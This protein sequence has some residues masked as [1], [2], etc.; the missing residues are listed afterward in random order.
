MRFTRWMTLAT[1]AALLAVPLVA[2]TASQQSEAL[3]HSA[4]STLVVNTTDDSDDGTCNSTH[5]SLREAINEA[6]QRAGPDTIAFNIPG[7]DPGCDEE[8][9]CTLRLTSEL[10]RLRDDGTTFDGYTQPGALPNTN[11]FGQPINAVLKIVLDGSSQACCP[12]GL[13]IQSSDNVVRGLVIQ[14]FHRGLRIFHGHRN[15]IEGN[16]LG[17]GAH[18]NGGP[19]NRGLG[20]D[21][22]DFVGAAGSTNNILGGSAP[23]ARNLIS[24]NGGGGVYLGPGG[25]NRVQGNYIGTDASGGAPLPNSKNGVRIS[26]NSLHH[27]IGG[28]SEREANV[29]AFN[30]FNGI[31]IEGS[32]G[33]AAHI[34]ISRNRIHDNRRKGISLLEGANEGLAAPVI[35]AASANQVQGTACAFCAVEVFSDAEDEGAVYEGT[36]QADAAGNWVLTKAGGLT[37]PHVTSTATDG[38]DN[39]SEFSAPVRIA[40]PTQTPTATVTATPTATPTCTATPTTP[41]VRHTTYLPLILK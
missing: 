1:V 35:T 38:K 16:S 33:Q 37:G 25:K 26:E 24:G 21:I 34:R 32:D 19:G 27:L 8:G 10:P 9:V 22:S 28:A 40:E 13:D 3:S 6:N 12:T 31:Q 17:A 23:Q 14:G 18:R 20:V 39:T 11:R 7:S 15:R 2:G 5:C 36:T 29:I 41:V 30:G 4:A